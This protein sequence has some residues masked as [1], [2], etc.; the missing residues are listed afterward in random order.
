MY[1]AV[2]ACRTYVYAVNAGFFLC[3]GTGGVNG[4]FCL[5]MK[6]LYLDFSVAIR[7]K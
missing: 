6:A 3:G 7:Y 5:F 2:A 4:E 1:S